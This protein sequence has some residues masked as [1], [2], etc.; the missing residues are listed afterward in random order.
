[1]E[2]ATMNSLKELGQSLIR[3][4]EHVER[5]VDYQRLLTI[6]LGAAFIAD[7][8]IYL[9]D[10]EE[11]DTLCMAVDAGDVSLAFKVSAVGGTSMVGLIMIGGDTPVD[12]SAETLRLWKDN[13]RAAQP[14]PATEQ[15]D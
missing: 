4:S 8:P 2:G 6:R 15:R 11:Y 9:P 1:M 5:L 7:G 12:L 3:Q 14:L 10:C 13:R